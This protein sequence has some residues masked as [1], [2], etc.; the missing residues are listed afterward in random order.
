MKAILY[1]SQSAKRLDYIAEYIFE[2]L[3]G[4]PLVI[5]QDKEEYLSFVGLRCNYSAQTL[6]KKEVHIPPGGLLFESGIREQ[7][8][9]SFPV[10]E[11]LAFFA[12][13]PGGSLPFDPF[14]T[15]FFL[16]SRYEEYLSYTPDAHGR[17]PVE[18]SWAYRN[19]CLAYPIVWQWTKLLRNALAKEF[20]EWKPEPPGYRFLPTYDIDLPWAYRHRGV[21]GLARAGL[22]LLSGDWAQVRTRWQVLRG[23]QEDPFD[24]FERLRQLHAENDLRPRIF[25]LLAD[26]RREDTNPAWQLAAY[27]D[28]IRRVSA[29]SDVGIH[30]GYYSWKKESVI[31][32]E[33]DR[34]TSILEQEVTHSRQHFLRLHLPTTYR[35]LLAAGIR[36]DYSLGFAAQA[37]YR[38]GTTEPFRWYDLAREEITQLWVHP[39]TVMD[40]TLKQY[41]ACDPITARA[42]LMNMQAYCQK[43]GLSFCTLWHNSSFSSAH[44]WGA[45]WEVYG[46]L[47]EEG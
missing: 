10:G 4:L 19:N 24:T 45:W 47:F 38:A 25:W 41:Q 9:T 36:H 14:A 15:S 46:A 26:G 23:Q 16:L 8:L 7:K 42:T 1:C 33:K 6:S 5:T 34:L 40:V 21:R 18:M 37:G 20:P 22:D 17:Y 12:I 32:R 30:P 28:L 35:A 31:R 43:E 39:F 3:L 11:V 29:W 13:R 27:Q 44:G 2:Q